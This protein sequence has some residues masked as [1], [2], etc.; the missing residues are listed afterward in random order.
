MGA[1][2]SCIIGESSQ[3]GE[4]ERQ[5][6][7]NET[8][9]DF[10]TLGAQLRDAKLLAVLNATN[11]RLIDHDD[12]TEAINVKMINPETSQKVIDPALL[13][14]AIQIKDSI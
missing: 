10:D 14:S 6:L 12:T 7:L 1:L 9:E 5:L 8:N 4:G 3:N 2:L 11:D 13:K